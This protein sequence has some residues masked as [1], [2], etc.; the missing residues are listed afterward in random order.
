M[1][2]GGHIRLQHLLQ[3]RFGFRAYTVTLKP[4]FFL[5]L[6]RRVAMGKAVGVPSSGGRT[7]GF[8]V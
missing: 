2:F 6:G 8:G 1:G 3:K 7:Y 5:G 4:H